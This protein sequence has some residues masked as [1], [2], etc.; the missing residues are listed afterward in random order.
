MSERCVC[1]DNKFLVSVRTLDLEHCYSVDIIVKRF[2]FLWFS[3][4]VCVVNTSVW[5]KAVKSR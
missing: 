2:V 5:G 4:L 3:I 1:Y